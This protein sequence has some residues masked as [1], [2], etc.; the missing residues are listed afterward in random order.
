MTTKNLLTDPPAG[1]SPEGSAPTGKEP[2][3]AP[4]P[5]AKGESSDPKKDDATPA[6]KPADKQSP[7]AADDAT[8]QGAPDVYEFKPHDSGF[9]FDKEVLEAFSGTAKE[10]KL[11]NEGAQKVLDSIAPA[12]VAQSQRHVNTLNQQWI[13][14]TTADAEIGG[15]K[16]EASLASARKALTLGTPELRK[17]LGPAAEGGSG[18]GNHPEVIRF[19]AT[20]GKALSEDKF[21]PAGKITP[22][23]NKT[24]AERMYPTAKS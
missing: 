20:I 4:T 8:P 15:D 17:L 3:G 21:V 6:N 9:S 10:L 2:A 22:P 23:Q 5:P 11:T 13:D 19:L 1:S 24:F 18:F 14:A 7:A 12:L 16:L